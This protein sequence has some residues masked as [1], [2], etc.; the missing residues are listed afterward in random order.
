MGTRGFIG[1]KTNGIITGKY[2]HMDSYYDELGFEI[3]A[4]YFNDVDIMQAGRQN[5]EVH[6]AKNVTANDLFITNGLFC[7]YA[8]IYNTDNDTLEIYRGFFKSPQWTSAFELAH[9]KTKHYTHIVMVVDKQIHSIEQVKKAM[10]SY[11]EMEDENV[12]YPERKII[13]MC[14]GCFKPLEVGKSACDSKCEALVVA[15]KV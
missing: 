13:N 3:L 4:L 1:T 12:L 8:Y 6:T 9:D 2:N 5:E 7:E 11:L 10:D 14:Q 15:R